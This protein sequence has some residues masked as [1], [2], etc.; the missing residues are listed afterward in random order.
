MREEVRP[1][2]YHSKTHTSCY[3]KQI[4]KSE[5]NRRLSLSC[6]R[7]CVYAK[8]CKVTLITSIETSEILFSCSDDSGFVYTGRHY[9][10]SRTAEKNTR[11]W[12]LNTDR[13]YILRDFTSNSLLNRTD[14]MVVSGWMHKTDSWNSYL[15]LSLFAFQSRS[16]ASLPIASSYCHSANG[17]GTHRVDS[18]Q[19]K[20]IK[21]S[22]QEGIW[23][24]PN[25]N[26]YSVYRSR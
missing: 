18:Y 22:V 21:H 6:I 3:N 8:L 23:W 20:L 16:E 17:L 9:S 25:T 19:V 24:A 10:R 5:C 13:T 12:G 1:L 4:I 2:T 14:W 15:S 7:L 26:R 11:C